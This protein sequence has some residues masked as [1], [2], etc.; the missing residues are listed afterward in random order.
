MIIVRPLV[1]WVTCALTLL[2][3]LAA[4]PRPVWAAVALGAAPSRFDVAGEPG[5]AVTNAVWVSNEG[6]KSLTVRAYALDRR[7]HGLT[8]GF[9]KPGD[10]LDSPSSWVYAQPEEFTLAPKGQQQVT[11]RMTVPEGAAPG[12]HTAVLF[13]DATPE[14]APGTLA[15]GARV[16][17][18]INIRVPGQV[19]VAGRLVG[20]TLAPTG[21]RKTG[22][23]VPAGKGFPTQWVFSG[24]P[25]NVTAFVENT[26]NVKLPV[27]GEVE[28]QNVWGRHVASLTLSDAAPVY[29]ESTGGLTFRWERPPSFGA[30]RLQARLAIVGEQLD[31]SS[32]LVAVLF[33]GRSTLSALLI[34]IGSLLLVAQV[35]SVRSTARATAKAALSRSPQE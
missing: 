9:E 23:R 28:V 35:R 27:A 18:I 1:T 2:G 14:P 30:Y 34:A 4:A 13:F 3:L 8:V 21:Q 31:A 10:A 16:G 7:A 32:A 17:S 24:G 29:P 11:W 22:A 19:V 33:P 12:D 20:L 6:D 15:I 25:L 26:G 5:R